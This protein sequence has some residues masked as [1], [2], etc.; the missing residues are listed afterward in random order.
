MKGGAVIIFLLSAAGRII[1]NIM[2]DLSRF[3]E[4]QK[5]DYASALANVRAGKKRS[6]WIWYIFP[7]IT[8]LG[9]SPPSRHYAIK[10]LEEAADYL[11]DPVLGGHLIEISE[12]LLA[13]DSCNPLEVMG[14]P[15]DL[16]LRSCMTLFREA[17]P[18]CEVFQKVLDKFYHGEPDTKTLKILAEAVC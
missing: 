18:S 5:N 4:A 9:D 16:K 17:D 10:S 6:H 3:H 2:N 13:L 12:A 15:D 7:Q 14:P 8:G 11:R 1:A